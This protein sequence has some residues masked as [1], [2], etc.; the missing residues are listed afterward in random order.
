MVN[1]ILMRGG[2][3][4]LDVPGPTPQLVKVVGEALAYHIAPRRLGS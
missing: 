1:T 3:L 2:R 4:I